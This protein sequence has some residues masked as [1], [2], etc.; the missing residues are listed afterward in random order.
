[1]SMGE[2]R[3]KIRS[4]LFL[5]LEEDYMNISDRLEDD[6]LVVN[7]SITYE[8]LLKILNEARKE[9]PELPYELWDK[10]DQT[11]NLDEE[12]FDALKGWFEKWFGT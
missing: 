9:F 5:C 10:Y 12:T 11:F 4:K 2:L 1:M 8:D 6:E 3:K 7:G